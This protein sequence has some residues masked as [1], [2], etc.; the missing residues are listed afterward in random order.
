MNRKK[1]TASRVSLPARRGAVLVV[2][3]VCLAI[4]TALMGSMLRSAAARHRTLRLEQ[5]RIQAEWL[6]TSALD[7][8]AARLAADA[9][10]SGEVWNVPAESLGGADGGVVQIEVRP[11]TEEPNDRLVRVRA[12]YPVDPRHRARKTKEAVVTVFAQQEE[13]P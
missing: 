13:D 6:A 10:Y 12:D 11:M 1:T 7:R 9:D 3:L 4:A 5:R 2:V 8:A